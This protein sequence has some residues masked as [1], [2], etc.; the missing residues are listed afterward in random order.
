MKLRSRYLGTLVFVCAAFLMAQG[1]SSSSDDKDAVVDPGAGGE[2][3]PADLGLDLGLDLPDLPTTG[4]PDTPASAAAKRQS[5]ATQACTQPVNDLVINEFM[6]YPVG[7]L[8]WI[9]I[10]NPTAAT[11][12]LKDWVIGNGTT[13]FTIPESANLNID[14]LSY[15]VLCSEEEA[16]CS[17]GP[18]PVG[19][20]LA[21]DDAS[22]TLQKMSADPTPVL[23]TVDTV[24]YVGNTIPA[25]GGS[26][27]LKH[28][29]K[30]NAVLFD[31]VGVM[32]ANF[33]LST[34]PLGTPQV[35]NDNYAV[36][37]DATCA[38][39]GNVCTFQVCEK[40]LCTY[41]GDTSC[42]L[43]KFDC[44]DSNDPCLVP[45]CD[46]ATHKCD[47]G[48]KANC[49]KESADCND[50][51]ACTT[52]YC[53]FNQ[54]QFTLGTDC[55]IVD[56][57]CP[58]KGF[59]SATTCGAV[60]AHKCNTVTIPAP[61][62]CTSPSDCA[63]DN[64]CTFDN[65]D[66]TTHACVFRPITGCCLLD[67]DCNDGNPCTDDKCIS[68]ACRPFWKVDRCCWDDSQCEVAD[69]P[70]H[71]PCTIDQCVKDTLTG[72]FYC[73][74]PYVANCALGLPYLQ[75][76]ANNT[77]FADINWQMRDYGTRTD[78]N[79][80]FASGFGDLGPDGHLMFN[81]TPT[82]VLVKTVAIAPELDALTSKND[83]FNTT[84]N[85]TV[86]WRM[87][88]H[89]KNPGQAVWI[90][91]RASANN[92]FTTLGAYQELWST[93]LPGAPSDL[94]TKVDLPYELHSEQLDPAFRF[95]QSLRIGFMI[96]TKTSLAGTANMDSL[97]VDD[98]VVAAGLPS[99]MTKSLL[100]R[101]NGAPGCNLS[102]SVLEQT[103]EYPED[104]PAV[105]A[106]SCDW[107]RIYMCMHDPDGTPG[108]WNFFGYPSAYIDG[109]PMDQTSVIRPVPGFGETG[110]QTFGPTVQS[111]CGSPTIGTGYYVCALDVKADC[112]ADDAAP[113]CAVQAAGA[114]RAALV[115]RD[116]TPTGPLTPLHSPFETQTNFDVTVLIE[117]GYLVWSPNGR[118]AP[119]AK[120]I[121][122]TIMSTRD[123]R[124]GNKFRQAQIVANLD[125]LTDQNLKRFRGVF[126]VL[127]VAGNYHV[128]TPA[129][130]SKLTKYM[131]EGGRMYL[132]GGDFF[133]TS[134]RPGAQP[135][136][137]LL[138][139]FVDL[140]DYFKIDATSGGLAVLDGPLAGGNFLNGYAYDFV[141]SSP[142]YNSYIDRL[143]HR[144]GSGSREIMK[145]A[146]ATA[147]ATTISFESTPAAPAGPFYRTIGSSVSFGGLVEQASQST[148]LNLMGR[149]LD[150]LEI[151]YPDCLSAAQC[152]DDE[153]CTADTC[154]P[155]D[156]DGRRLCGYSLP[157]GMTSCTPC[158]NDVQIERNGQPACSINEACNVALGYCVAI[159]FTTRFDAEAGIATGCGN[160]FGDSDVDPAAPASAACTTTVTTSGI[161]EGLQV[162]AMVPHLY[163][164]DIQLTLTSPSGTPVRLKPADPLDAV[165]NVYATYDVGVP[166]DQPLSR[167]LGERLQ[168]AWTLTAQDTLPSFAGGSITEW[169]LYTKQRP[170]TCTVASECIDDPCAS[171]VACVATAVP[172]VKIC[173]YTPLCNDDNVC[174][175]DVC[176]AGTQTAMGTGAC[177]FVATPGASCACVKHDDCL[178]DQ[179]CLNLGQTATCA[180]ESDCRC[181]PVPGTPHELNLP[182]A[183][184]IPDHD[185]GTGVTQ[186]F[187]LTGT[188]PIDHIKVRV[189]ADHPS[190]EDLRARLCHL[191]T[192]VTLR[193]VRKKALGEETGFHDVYNFDLVN[194]PGT[195]DDFR[196]LPIAGA[197]N[198]TMFD[199]VPGNTGTLRRATL[200]TQ[201][202]ECF[203]DADCSDNNAC[204]TDT[205]R[206]AAPGEAGVC[207]HT[208]KTCALPALPV[209]MNADCVQTPQCI[210]ATGE[211]PTVATLSFKTIGTTC[212]DGLFCTDGDQCNATGGCVAGGPKDCAIL[213]GTCTEGWCDPVASEALKQCAVRD[214]A[215]GSFCNDGEA[216]NGADSCLSG[217]CASGT[218]YGICPCRVDG[219]CADDGNKCNGDTWFCNASKFCELDLVGHPRKDL[220][221]VTTDPCQAKA[222]EPATGLCL[223]TFASANFMP[224]ND[225]QF[226]TLGD[227]CLNG[228]CL[229]GEVRDCSPL[230][231]PN[232]MNE[233]CGT[234]TCVGTA[235]DS[236]CTF[237]PEPNT[238]PCDSNGLGCDLEHCN[239]GACI[240][241]DCGP[242]DNC[243]LVGGHATRDCSSYVDDCNT[244]ACGELGGGLA[245]CQRTAKADYPATPSCT[246]D[247]N[248]CTT[249]GCHSGVCTHTWLQT[250]PGVVC[251]GRHRY[252][253]GDD[254]CGALDSCLGGAPVEG[255]PFDQ[256][257]GLCV[258]TCDAAAGC[259]TF[260]SP[261]LS[262]PIID[263]PRVH[264]CTTSEI[265]IPASYAPTYV[266][267]LEA[268]VR[269]SHS[270]LGDLFVSLKDPQGYTHP[271]WNMIGG[272]NAGF[273]D[274]FDLSF[275]VPTLHNVPGTFTDGRNIAG[276][277]M[278]SFNGELA[279]G[280][281][282][283]WTLEV[284][285]YGVTNS[286]V[287]HD[288]TLAIKGTNDNSAL[289]RGHRCEDAIDLTP[290]FLGPDPDI[291]SIT[292]DT[293]KCSVNVLSNSGFGKTEGPERWYKLVLDKPT[294][295]KVTLAQPIRNL[296]LILKGGAAGTCDSAI[297]NGS[298]SFDPASGQAEYF[299]LP[300]MEGT[301]YLAVDTVSDP[302][303]AGLDLISSRL[304]VANNLF[305]YGP[306]S[307]VINM[308]LLRQN[309]DGCLNLNSESCLSDYCDGNYCCD[310][311]LGTNPTCCPGAFPAHVNQWNLDAGALPIETTLF[312]SAKTVCGVDQLAYC[313]NNEPGFAP[314]EGRRVFPNC[315][316]VDHDCFRDFANPARDDTACTSAATAYYCGRYVDVYCNGDLLQTPVPCK[317]ECTTD[318][319]CKHAPDY[320]G[321]FNHCE[322]TDAVTHKKECVPDRP[323]GGVCGRDLEC[324]D[325]FCGENGF[326]C[327]PGKLCCPTAGSFV[328][329]AT[330]KNALGQD[331]FNNVILKDWTTK[332]CGTQDQCIGSRIDPYCNASLECEPQQIRDD[333]GCQ[334]NKRD[335]TL[336][337]TFYDMP[338][339]FT[340]TEKGAICTATTPVGGVPRTG[341]T[342]PTCFTSCLLT[343]SNVVGPT[344]T[345]N[346]SGG[347][348]EPN[349]NAAGFDCPVENPSCCCQDDTKCIYL[350]RCAAESCVDGNGDPILYANGTPICAFPAGD[351]RNKS[352][353]GPIPN[354]GM[355]NRG[356]DC[357]NKNWLAAPYAGKT[358]GYC[359]NNVCC[360]GGECCLQEATPGMSTYCQANAPDCNDPLNC[361]GRNWTNTCNP[362][363]A[364]YNIHDPDIL[365]PARWDFWEVE[366]SMFTCTGNI[367]REDDTQCTAMVSNS[368]PNN[369]APYICKGS[370]DADHP[371]PGIT[372]FG[373]VVDSRCPLNC[374]K[375]LCEKGVTSC[376]LCYGVVGDDPNCCPPDNPACCCEENTICETTTA[377]C[378]PDPANQTT[379]ACLDNG[380]FNDPCN[381]NS[382]CG[383]GLSCLMHFCCTAGRLSECKGYMVTSADLVFASGGVVT[384]V[385]ATAVPTLNDARSQQIIVG[386]GSPVGR[387]V[388]VTG[389]I[390]L[391]F[392]ATTTVP[393]QCYDPLKA[394]KGVTETD[395][396]CGG[397]VCPPCNVASK[398]AMDSDCVTGVCDPLD[399]KCRLCS[400]PADCHA[401]QTC[402]GGFC[403]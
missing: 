145:N 222:C 12:Q 367:V 225:N 109:A 264:E 116:E 94:G 100:Y 91:V 182:L 231:L 340:P 2:D 1:C 41:V 189:A 183:V 379:T 215:N 312:E 390:D 54:C 172:G 246:T 125:I 5:A 187:T 136:Y 403:Q 349:C 166:S 27:E 375:P 267:S 149:Y 315:S 356:P 253:A 19:F 369:F 52:D 114:Y 365:D 397:A 196:R 180:G 351:W 357:L 96:D 272:P 320:P 104:V 322:E 14:P 124:N 374:N 247:G 221:C 243:I 157:A 228:T 7:V 217:D 237:V 240:D 319:D 372:Y 137:T 79:W 348:T 204:S 220:L 119:A 224:C 307:F 190:V 311:S 214:L 296:A 45:F 324:L 283:K 39:D 98:V 286:G 323:K 281:T 105:T 255:Q 269:V 25:T 338:E 4:L 314:C 391:G 153:V 66:G 23:V 67:G 60:E 111:I 17:W 279:R 355:C 95:S 74:Q 301:Y 168:G 236:G 38:D 133:Y 302:V 44:A 61:A 50:N 127:G 150:F 82:A 24:S 11:I 337:N 139:P 181:A 385:A 341:P 167:F 159:P 179:A 191:G 275:D 85:T 401:P 188:T 295:V 3:T 141:Q 386:Q 370:T 309:G 342:A 175:R 313:H 316:D 148:L 344:G 265:V 81:W 394:T 55:C 13:T 21:A 304:A 143:V 383:A 87:A 205:C 245:T 132:E 176:T 155:M 53:L 317:L 16:G 259:A 102:D 345:V 305:N 83:G 69:R 213:N 209:G 249:D 68:N 234:R 368:C 156:I 194:G 48:R 20:V 164:G 47:N 203:F 262:L 223:D 51:I 327:L 31:Q 393:A 347:A 291:R 395:L 9:E 88:Y 146:G 161:L 381:E 299:N 268:K 117:D 251:G 339:C 321:V 78:R 64:P 113:D 350:A 34:N 90:S 174:T 107:Y 384:A 22:I 402:V 77:T 72:N 300:L 229:G 274:T 261:L 292:G 378:D 10:Y 92:D 140:H 382:D 277:P 185:A 195:L 49:C 396:K 6:V 73:I 218:N 332:T 177:S 108:T 219:D 193:D 106:G 389:T 318:S 276:G 36:V 86:Q 392:G 363:P 58:S 284:C 158:K 271:I 56:S 186:T 297:I 241:T 152:Q 210:A 244:A 84:Q 257:N 89:H 376:A 207:L 171:A 103:A 287:L 250:C 334:D 260:S 18:W 200:Y 290:A 170:V 162:K 288:W 26:I 129:E 400:G 263:F 118:D 235:P 46:P 359:H 226:C 212:E 76:F 138:P 227:Y 8:Q 135:Y 93:K 266:Q 278:C 80:S 270:Y 122:N 387:V 165:Q 15:V 120:A 28:P 298:N 289:N 285:D 201:E 238:K 380:V 329:G 199:V 57:D 202:A 35:K 230:A 326:C 192:C 303:P 65:C 160:F 280:T 399:G 333:C 373:E 358:G 398:C 29:Y 242:F 293:T 59:C 208:F 294:R 352:C 142:Q 178:A 173:Q 336:I 364:L 184:A 110:C 115:S 126:A 144:P 211:C 328:A 62:C 71:K 325:D 310:N 42:C 163:R 254:M 99:R 121:A 306:Y 63:D 282:G 206:S 330:C 101:C 252:D 128:V 232:G 256:K 134:N 70:N 248:E 346:C 97:E 361:H 154:L 30:D 131:D 130:E 239:A 258:K 353:T 43:S 151:G 366:G 331:T 33:S 123:A 388:G 335:C 112:C 273:A 354:G 343:D 198:L 37:T 75:P 308:E 197:W 360:N 147:F 233:T 362:P 40:S 32:N 169:H 216:C 371:V 377:H